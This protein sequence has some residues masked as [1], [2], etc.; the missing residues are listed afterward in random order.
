[1]VT[2]NA[3]Q[4]AAFDALRAELQADLVAGAYLSLAQMR[5]ATV[6]VSI[7]GLKSTP[8]KEY[9]RAQFVAYVDPD[10]TVTR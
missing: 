6:S 4:L 10:G 3:S 8:G 5:G 2:L 9:R 7:A 1:M